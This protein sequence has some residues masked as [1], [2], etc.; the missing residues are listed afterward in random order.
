M[1]NAELKME[2]TI[3]N[4][5]SAYGKQITIGEK[6]FGKTNEYRIFML[7]LR[8]CYLP[9]ITTLKLRMKF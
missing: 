4:G 8:Q 5:S 9:N 2:K 6:R 3:K 7:F 1:K